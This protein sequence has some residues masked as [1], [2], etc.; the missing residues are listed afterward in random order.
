[1]STMTT[2]VRRGS[3]RETWRLFVR[4]GASKPLWGTLM[5]C[6]VMVAQVMFFGHAARPGSLPKVLLFDA[7]M[8]VFA[9]AMGTWQL[10]AEMGERIAFMA[11]VAQPVDT[12]RLL[13]VPMCTLGLV[14][15]SALAIGQRLP[16]AVALAL[17]GVAW[18]TT[19]ATRWLWKVRFWPLW[20]L[21]LL[22]ADPAAAWF[23]HRVAGWGAAAAISMAL[24]IGGLAFQ[25][26]PYVGE[27]MSRRLNGGGAAPARDLVAR[28]AAGAISAPVNDRGVRRLLAWARGEIFPIIATVL[29]VACGMLFVVFGH[30]LEFVFW[31]MV[32]GMRLVAAYSGDTYEF[33]RPL[34]YSRRRHFVRTVGPVLFVALVVPATAVWFVN[35][36][37]FNHDGLLGLISRRAQVLRAMDIAYLR[38]VLGA[39]F[40]PEKW[41]AG[42]I[43]L[44]LWAR[45]RPLLYLD[46]LRTSILSVAMLFA[47]PLRKVGERPGRQSLQVTNLVLML[48]VFGTVFCNQLSPV[49]PRMP[50]PRL[51]FLA[52]LA[53]VS[54]AHFAWKVRVINSPGKSAGAR[55]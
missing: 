28:R 27:P 43:S 19:A 50:V 18:S 32:C 36:D 13:L 26:R 7:F 35:F 14:M 47:V 33:L 38:H 11:I 8:M 10:E 29:G 21:P 1:M 23:V 44:D 15:T 34:P 51:W 22:V 41:P 48:A 5:I 25:P 31:P 49:S 6:A 42:G 16:L 4:G 20:L 39:T 52:L 30:H 12:R 3:F 45:L 9:L 54:I 37:W 40:L 55:R 24:A 17:L 46:I 2:P 53:C